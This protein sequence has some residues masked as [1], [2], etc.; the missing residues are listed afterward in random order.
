MAL[1]LDVG[2]FFRS[3]VVSIPNGHF[4]DCAAITSSERDIYFFKCG[5]RA[6]WRHEGKHVDSEVS[7]WGVNQSVVEQAGGLL[8]SQ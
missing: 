8:F 3:I 5:G 1:L 6:L 7:E 4:L 2:I